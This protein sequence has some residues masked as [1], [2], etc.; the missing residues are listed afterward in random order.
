MVSKKILAALLAITMILSMLEASGV[1]LAQ[2]SVTSKTP[3]QTTLTIARLA[4]SNASL[5]TFVRLL[6]KANLTNTLNRSGNF[7]VFAPTNAAFAKMNNSTLAN[8]ENNSTALKRLLKYHIVKKRVHASNLTRNGTLKTLAGVTLPYTVNKT[9]G[10]RVDNA[11][12]TAKDINA[13]NG[14]MYIVDSVMMPP[15]KAT[16]ATATATATASSKGGFLGLPGFEVVYG[17]AALIAVAYL[18]L[19]RRN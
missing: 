2:T 11:S 5:S 15:A 18:A 7:T 6:T 12:V 9:S 16:T 1:A 13:T 4:A 10:I 8:L 19:R 14:V 17:V 3:A